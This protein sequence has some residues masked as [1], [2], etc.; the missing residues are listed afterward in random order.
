MGNCWLEELLVVE[1][2]ARVELEYVEVA[3]SGSELL[4]SRHD[5]LLARSLVE[6]VKFI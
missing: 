1:V 5:V 2:L 6:T 4:R 3:T